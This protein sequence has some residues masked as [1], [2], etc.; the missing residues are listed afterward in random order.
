M[1][2]YSYITLLT[3]DS[4][5]FGVILLQKSLKDVESQY[6]LE[7]IVTSNVSPATINILDQ[8]NLKYHIIEPVQSEKMMDYNIKIN[9]QFANTWVYTLSKFE[10]F[11]LTQ[12][13]KIVYLDA[14]VLVLKNL[15]H[16]FECS[17]MTS[18]LDGE[19]YNIWPN[20]PHFNAGIFVLEPNKD[21][22]NKIMK[23]AEEQVTK[24]NE[25][26]CVADQE[27][28][29]LYFP[30]WISNQSLHLN[31]YYDIFAPYVQEE[32]LD[33]IKAN[34]YF[35]H[36]IGRKPWRNFIKSEQETYSEYF[37]TVA[38]D[39]I[40]NELK[41]I[42]LDETKKYL[43]LAI[44]GICKDE[45]VNVKQYIE[46][47]SKADYICILDTGSTD[48][49]WE[50]LQE[51]Q[52]E[53]PNLI[54]E[55]K[56]FDP[57]RYDSARNYSLTL[58]PKDTTI[59]FMMD[60]DELIHDDDWVTLI[61]NAWNPMFLRGEY[62]YNR[63]IDKVSNAILQQFVE[64]R[65]HN[66]SWHYKGIVH[67]QLCNYANQR[68]FFSDEC[69]KVPIT[70]WHYSTNPNRETYIELCERGVEEEPLNWLM[71]LQLAAEY[72]IHNHFDEAINEYRKIIAEQTTL[73][74]PE[75]G[76][77]YASLGRALFNNGKEEEGIAVLNKGIMAAPEYSDNYF[78]LGEIYYK[79]NKFKETY[80]ICAA[81]VNNCHNSYWCTIVSNNSYFPYLLMGVSRYNMGYAVEG[82]GFLSIAREKNNTKEI[83]DIFNEM[84]NTII[85][86][87]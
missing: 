84:I 70:V 14:D 47:F 5:I 69:V 65:I 87:G 16:L 75:I 74:G 68:D 41:N 82:L 1:N 4:Y 43:K 49:T 38:K 51:A 60:L 72:E 34:A 17:H 46:C 10:I 86:R 61:K 50:Y 31:K 39:I 2:N 54:V 21:E 9:P 12:Y 23:F 8:L 6:T 71:H 57:W 29:N 40:Q 20:N 64:F 28:L 56:V 24:W 44:Y 26:Q 76:R 7:V 55:Q 37:Y 18:A 22:Y 62:T 13:D 78:F 83:N 67:E 19:Y 45:I 85:N 52:K 59:Y 3:N 32:D 48:G 77:C 35:I 36:F 53:Y 73:Q 66:N 30:E 58:V 80:E 81:G 11:G 79:Q 25:P 15:D 63:Q 42:N 33:D 27:I